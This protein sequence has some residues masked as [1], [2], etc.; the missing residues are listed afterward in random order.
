VD[1]TK[2]WEIARKAAKLEDFRFHDLRHSAASYLAEQGASM[3]EIAEILGHRT[4]QMVR[5]YSHIS[6]SHAHGVVSRMNER[7]FNH[8][9]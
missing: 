9:K 7:I 8:G 6:D 5:R 1:V 3:V 4:L 2:P